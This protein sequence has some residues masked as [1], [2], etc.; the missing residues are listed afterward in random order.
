[1]VVLGD[2]YSSWGVFSRVHCW[3]TVFV[4]VVAN[5]ACFSCSAR[6]RQCLC[7]CGLVWSRGFPL[8]GPSRL[9][10]I[11]CWA[12]LMWPHAVGCVIFLSS[13]FFGVFLVVSVGVVTGWLPFQLSNSR[14]RCGSGCS[15]LCLLSQSVVYCFGVW[16]Q[17]NGAI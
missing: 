8:C 14:S 1:M 7:C 12:Y 13:S 6:F 3:G 9:V 11:R 15:V 2:S 10:C 17:Q 5:A 4:I 16:T